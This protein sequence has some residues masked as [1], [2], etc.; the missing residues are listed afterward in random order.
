MHDGPV[1]RS[2]V[3]V[4]VEIAFGVLAIALIAWLIH[5]MVANGGDDAAASST[6][7]EHAGH[8]AEALVEA[9][10]V[11]VDALKPGER[12]ID[13]GMP[14]GSYT[15]Q[16]TNGGT[17]D[18]R[19]ILLDPQLTS[20]AYLTSV[21]LQPGIAGEVHHAILYRVDP[22][23]VAQAHALDA[24]DPSLGWSCFG[25]PGLQSTATDTTGGLA[26]APWV[27]AFATTGGEQHFAPGTGQL[28]KAHSELILQMHYN[29]LHGD[30][31]DD[32]SLKL[33]V[34]P[35]GTKLQPLYTDL[36]PAPVELP[37][38]A[39][40]TGP[41][42]D[43]GAALADVSKRFGPQAALVVA[44][45]QLICD[46]TNPLSNW[47]YTDRSSCI[48]QVKQPMVIQAAAGHMHMLGTSISV[49]LTRANGKTL[50]LY[51]QPVWNFDDQRARIL[52]KPVS[53]GPGDTITTTC[54]WDPTL[55][56]K[57]PALQGLP[58]RYI[59]WGEGSSDEM[60]LGILT[61]TKP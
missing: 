38:P 39:G 12:W 10:P 20:D 45:L 18:Y 59:V 23:E 33:R 9:A 16:A 21:V 58:P 54:T 37:C 4:A 15:P 7:S 53:V 47:A 57:L 46:P 13:L 14:G 50:T 55:R 25:G 1:T 6:T 34:A 19:C 3:F 2:R 8:T 36:L 44:G 43:R 61:Y 56:T 24:A 30:A 49:V 17:D 48:N 5:V 22:G 28:L 11:K 60:C 29:L 32:S 40:V 35:V 31:P 41:L 51:D 52:K 26:C 42:C 27:A